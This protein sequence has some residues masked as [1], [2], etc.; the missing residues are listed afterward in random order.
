MTLAVMGNTTYG[1]VVRRST[2]P[3]F[4]GHRL[5][6]TGSRRDIRWVSGR[7]GRT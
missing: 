4:E 1:G 2:V 6:S 3:V 7:G 5:S